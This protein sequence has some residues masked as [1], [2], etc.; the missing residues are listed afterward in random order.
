MNN[1]KDEDAEEESLSELLLVA[2]MAA[3]AILCENKKT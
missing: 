3:V 1:T 2:G